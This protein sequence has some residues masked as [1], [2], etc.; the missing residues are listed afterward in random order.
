MKL[1]DVLALSDTLGH[2]MVREEH[3]SGREV[4]GSTLARTVHPLDT[5]PPVALPC[6]GDLPLAHAARI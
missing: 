3:Y 4:E 2:F 1:L 6:G 5:F